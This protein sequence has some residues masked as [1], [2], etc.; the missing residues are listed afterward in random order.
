M[1][2]SLITHHALRAPSKTVAVMPYHAGDVLFFLKALEGVT[3]PF[4]CLLIHKEY[5][6]IARAVAPDLELIL[7]EEPPSS[8]ETMRIRIDRIMPI[9]SLVFS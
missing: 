1:I 5:A 7:V 8:G 6:D 3:H 4:D 2:Y 9:L